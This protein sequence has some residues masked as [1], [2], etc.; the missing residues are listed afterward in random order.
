MKPNPSA[1]PTARSPRSCRNLFLAAALL[2]AGAPAAPAEEASLPLELF[3]YDAQAPLEVRLAPLG[4]EDGVGIFEVSYASPA[5]GRVTGR[6]YVPAG[7][8]PF[9]GIVYAHGTGA[10]ARTQGPRAVYLARHGA[11]VLT[12]DA[13]YIRRGGEFPTFTEFDRTEQIQHIQEMQRGFDLLLARADVDP[14]RLAFVGRS[15]GGAMG[16]L[17]AGVETRVKTYILIVADGGLVS[18]FAGGV[19]RTQEFDQLPPE[20][21]ARWLAAMEPIEP[22][23]FIHRAPS[24]SI[25]FQNGRQDDA[26]PAQLAEALHAAARGKIE[27]RW[28]DAG[29]RLNTQSFIDQLDWLHREIG[30]FAPGPDAD[31]GPK[32]PAPGKSH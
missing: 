28:Y 3:A 21:K 20:R 4:D 12:P 19:G 13:P 5:G 10:G 1:D 8:G 15:H 29:H 2:L 25:L 26:V 24:A 31:A 32:F 23:R 22:L 6:L 27:V 17:L 7:P 11:V 18:H 14:A 16:A 30:M 9:A